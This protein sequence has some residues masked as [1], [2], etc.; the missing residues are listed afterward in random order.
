M[1]KYDDDWKLNSLI[2]SI[3]FHKASFYTA[4]ITEITNT[5]SYYSLF[6]PLPLSYNSNYHYFNPIYIIISYIIICLDSRQ[7]NF[8]I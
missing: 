7:T 1:S 8:I 3:G 6:H 5:L 2:L 4:K